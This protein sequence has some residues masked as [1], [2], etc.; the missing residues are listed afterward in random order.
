M[1]CRKCNK[2]G[3]KPSTLGDDLVEQHFDSTGKPCLGSN[4]P[5]VEKPKSRRKAK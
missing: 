5:P 3:L 4:K 2:E 1:K